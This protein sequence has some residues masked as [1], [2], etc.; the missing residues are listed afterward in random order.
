MRALFNSPTK[1]LFTYR[2]DTEQ[3]T[4]SPTVYALATI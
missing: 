4:E 2:V 3:A 1:G